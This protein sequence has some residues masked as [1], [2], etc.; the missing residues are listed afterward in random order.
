MPCVFC[1]IV[2]KREP[3]AIRYED[4]DVIVI[5]NILRW[6]PVMLL[7][8]PKQHI[9]QQELWA[10]MGKV[11][12]IATQMGEEL[13]PGGYRLISN[14]GGDA[15]QSQEHGHIHILGGFNLGPYA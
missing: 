15:M 13:C 9:S 6:S 4:D 14:I 3:A 10:S 7:A 2:A 1:D 11:G 8:M 5:D 12:A